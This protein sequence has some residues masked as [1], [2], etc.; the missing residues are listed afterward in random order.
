MNKN[1][2]KLTVAEIIK[3]FVQ[4]SSHRKL[5]N[6]ENHTFENHVFGK[7]DPRQSLALSALKEINK[8]KK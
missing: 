6:V 2:P 1:L 7:D 8:N 5:I 3:K 4:P